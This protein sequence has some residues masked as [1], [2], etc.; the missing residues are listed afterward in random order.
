MKRRYPM[1]A[2]LASAAALTAMSAWAGPPLI[3]DQINIGDAKSLPW[4]SGNSWKLP[5]ASYDLARLTS[6]TLDLL[7]PGTPVIVRMETLRRA[8]IYAATDT[9]ATNQL[10][11]RLVARTLDAESSGKGDPLA[12]FDAGYFVETLKQATHVYEWDML[13]PSEKAKWKH[14][15]DS[16]KDF[17]GYNWLLKAIR[18]GGDAGSMHYA[19]SLMTERVQREEH[20][21]Q[22]A[23]A[24]RE[25]SLLTRNLLR[26]AGKD[27]RTL[28]DLRAKYAR[29]SR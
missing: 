20:L 6:D 5:D 19:A 27:A 18:L 17:N 8:A 26:H 29:A 4:S 16:L 12:W 28:A 15:G 7:A 3:C 21:Q 25:G 9:S 14:R 13:S 11:S 23:S 24:A 10:L 1:W 2:L 22:A